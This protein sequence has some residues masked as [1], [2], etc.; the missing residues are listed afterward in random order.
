VTTTMGWLIL[1]PLLIS[2]VQLG[3]V[4]ASVINTPLGAVKGREGVTS[5][6][7]ATLEYLGI[8]YGQP[9]VGNR[10]FLPALPVE[11]WSETFYNA[12]EYAAKCSQVVSTGPDAGQMQGEEDCLNLN[13]FLPKD[14][15]E[16]L[17]VMV[18]IHGGAFVEGSGQ[19]GTPDTFIDRGVLVVM[20][21]YRL[22]ALGFMTFGNDL[23]TGNM[24]LK[25]QLLALQWV[26][27]NIESYGGDPNK[28]TIFG[29]SAGAISVHAHVLSPLGRGLYR[30]AIAQS[31]TSDM[32]LLEEVGERE[33]VFSTQMA[34]ALN[35]SY[36]NHTQ[37]MLTCLQDADIE[38]VLTVL[39]DPDSL[40]QVSVQWWMV[41]DN[42][43]EDPFLPQ[44]PLAI[45]R[46]GKFKSLPYISGTMSSE[47]GFIVS[48]IWDT[49]AETGKNWDTVGP[50]FTG[51][52][53]NQDP[54]LF[55]EEQLIIARLIKDV[56]TGGNFT[57]QNLPALLK[58]FTH[59]GFLM[60]ERKTVSLMAMSSPNIYNYQM[61]FKDTFSIT[62][63]ISPDPSID[64][65]PVHA[66]DLYYQFENVYYPWV[67][68]SANY[69]E[70]E[71]QMS[72]IMAEYWTNF[73]KFSDPSPPSSSLPTWSPVPS[74]GETNVLDLKLEPEMK[75]ELDKD[76]E[77]FWQRL[78]WDHREG[79][80]DNREEFL[81]A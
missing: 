73:A 35:C 47:G 50:F 57:S 72:D 14:R 38:T 56:Y 69:T 62:N 48:A 25:D 11:P 22:G 45:M 44:A 16:L 6:G 68:E 19:D 3:N 32:A 5:S 29:E 13:I 70:K 20:I 7:V 34:V 78:V 51:L 75:T 49:I 9:P 54:A 18:W 61:T 33:E 77:F 76:K 24:G 74:S 41:I 39:S 28:V 71:Q 80:Q 46:S 21:N 43:A 8:P 65:G 12:T 37:E 66:D 42:Y 30:S 27:D 10:R 67:P 2:I 26:Q 60:P 36:T 1:S 79:G 4:N 81:C 55:F 15:Q 52:T 64:F 31:G 53:I 23:M 40:L 17:P 59:C 63:Y 58:M